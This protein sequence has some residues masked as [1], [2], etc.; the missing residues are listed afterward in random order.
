MDSSVAARRD[1]RF[2]D[3]PRDSEFIDDLREMMLSAINEHVT[4]RE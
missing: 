2:D 1:L 4:N 3:Y